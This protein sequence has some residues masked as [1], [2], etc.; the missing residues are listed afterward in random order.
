VARAEWERVRVVLLDIEGTTTPVDFVYKT[1]FPYA[2]TNVASF[3]AKR[4]AESEIQTIVTDLKAQHAADVAAGFAPPEWLADRQQE[5]RN[6]AAYAQWLMKRDSKCAPLKALQGKIW[7]R[8]YES[9]ELH[10]EIYPDVALAFA[11]WRG[12][13]RAI[14]IYSSGSVLAQKLLFGS[15]PSG[16]LTRDI[17]AFFDTAVGIKTAA[18]SYTKIAAAMAKAPQEF[19]FLSDAEKEVAAAGSAGMSAAL[20]VREGEPAGSSIDMVT[21]FDEV[22]PC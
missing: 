17:T 14:A 1:L 11:R 8:G 2:S 9:G 22:L 20:C 21:T 15:V 4:F 12:Q 7:Q 13:G 6:C 10:G 3:L 19:L 5:A 18:E 16:D